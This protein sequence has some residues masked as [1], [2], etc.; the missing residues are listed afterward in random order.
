METKQISNF[1]LSIRRAPYFYMRGDD[2]SNHNMKIGSSLKGTTVLRGLDLEEEKKYLPQII[3]IAPSDVNFNMACRDYWN[4]ISARVPADGDTAE[5]LQGKILSMKVEFKSAEQKST[6]ESLKSFEKK[7]N[8]ITLYG[9]VIDGIADYVLFKYCLVYGRVANHSKDVFIS[10]KIRF[11]LY[12]IET[13][14]LDKISEFKTRNDARAKFIEILS[15]EPV[16]DASLLYYGEKLAVYES[17]EDKQIALEKLV[18]SKPEIFMDCVSD[19]NLKYKAL[20][21]RAREAGILYVPANTDTY[22]YGENREICLGTNLDDAVLFIKSEEPK[23]KEIVSVIQ[24]R[25]KT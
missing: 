10:P 21:L 12:S 16:I 7:G 19:V 3:N 1:E 18:E 14:R 15:K 2:P 23:N 5:K 9:N 24:A 6:F 17:L 25:L 13:D 20:I 4:N 22:Y 11:Y 8:Y